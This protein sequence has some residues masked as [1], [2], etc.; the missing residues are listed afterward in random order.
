MLEKQEENQETVLSSSQG[1]RVF[2]ANGQGIRG[3]ERGRVESPLDLA[4]R[5]LVAE[6][7]FRKGG[8]QKLGC[9]G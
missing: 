5:S 3:C 6:E 2:Q 4:V 8:E 7:E 1:R 9:S